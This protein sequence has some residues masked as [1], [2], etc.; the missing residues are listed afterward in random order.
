M[1][2]DKMIKVL[3]I[4]DESNDPMKATAFMDNADSVGIYIDPVICVEE[5]ITK[6]KDLSV[7]Y[8]AIILDANCKITANSSEAPSM[9]ALSSAINTL[10][11][12]KTD[13]PWFVY[14]AANYEGTEHLKWI[15]K[16][17]QRP[18]DD[19][20][21]YVKPRDYS[22]LFDKIKKVVNKLSTPEY[23]IRNKYHLEI[24]SSTLIDGAEKYL[25]KFL[26]CDYNNDFTELNE[27]FIPIR[28]GIEKIFSY[29]QDWK[30]IPPISDDINGTADYFLFGSYREKDEKGRYKK[31]ANN[32]PILLYKCYD[33]HDP[34][35]PGPLAKSLNYVIDIVQD[36]AHSKEE[37]KLKVDE[38]WNNTHD[39]LL[40]KSCV[41][42][43]MDLLKWF[44]STLTNHQDKE[45]NATLWR[46]NK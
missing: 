11:S 45:I 20:D 33:P 23:K 17:G 43:Y 28:R 10:V 8:D 32:K 34:L 37:L 14:T 29:C 24:N 36:S 5:G 42:I 19:R 27:P 15:I 3:W 26:L 22:I 12:M 21:Y 35:M 18:Y 4:D 13:L 9:L 39:A 38:Y 41:F 1:N 6:L 31:D 30:L 40:L 44:A 46:E 7:S 16:G 2:D 25:M